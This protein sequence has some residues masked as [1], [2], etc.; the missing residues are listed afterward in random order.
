HVDL[1]VDRV[2]GHP[3]RGR[4]GDDRISDTPAFHEDAHAGERNPVL[5]RREVPRR[6]TRRVRPLHV[7]LQ[8][9]REIGRWRGGKLRIYA[10]QSPRALPGRRHAALAAARR[11]AASRSQVYP[12]AIRRARR[13]SRVRSSA[14]PRSLSMWSTISST[15]PGGWRSALLRCTR[16]SAICP[17]AL[18][19]IGTRAAAYSKI[20]SGEK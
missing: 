6:P 13:A 16:S 4:S 3:D 12:F 8:P 9:L 1:R 7:D 11:R 2:R 15:L 10:R 19:T 18:A 14:F 5:R 20:L 17:L